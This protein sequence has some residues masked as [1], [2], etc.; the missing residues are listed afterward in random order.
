[1][2]WT[3]MNRWTMVVSFG[4]LFLRLPLSTAALK[5][6]LLKKN[7][8]LNAW[9]RTEESS[10][11]QSKVSRGLNRGLPRSKIN[12]GIICMAM[13]IAKLS[14]SLASLNHLTES[15]YPIRMFFHS[16]WSGPPRLITWSM[17]RFFLILE[18]GPP[19]P[20]L[21]YP[22]RKNTTTTTTMTTQSSLYH[23]R[24]SRWVNWQHSNRIHSRHVVITITLKKKSR[25][26]QCRSRH[27]LHLRPCWHWQTTLRPTA[28][29]KRVEIIKFWLLLL[30][31]YH[32]LL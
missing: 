23:W 17:E 14:L 7:I 11:P 2:V 10:L 22:A 30:D 1:M 6:V 24:D 15:I 13:S 5:T 9:E 18:I 8:T 20:P 27:R 4:R 32:Q 12:I 28:S 31:C 19:S 16:I 26:G 25:Q 21:Y 29:T 3:K